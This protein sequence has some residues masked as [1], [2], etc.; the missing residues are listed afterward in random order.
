MTV[1][2]SL[3]AVSLQSNPSGAMTNT[4]TYSKL[5]WTKTPKE[6]ILDGLLSSTP[7]LPTD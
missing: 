1:P 7:L 6:E 5:A 4:Q 2:Y 3:Q